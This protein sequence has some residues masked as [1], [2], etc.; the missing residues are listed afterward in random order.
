[1][2]SARKGTSSE[3]WHVERVALDVA[4]AHEAELTGE[5]AR[6]LLRVHDITRP[7]LVLGSTQR[8]TDVDDAAAVLA[9]VDVVRRRSGGGAVLLTPGDV[10]WIDVVVPAGDPLWRDDVGVAF[11]WLGEVWVHALNAVGVGGAAV[12]RGALVRTEWSD[13]VCFAGL[14]PGEVTLYGA[15]TI[16][17]SQRRTRYASRFQ[18]AA[19]LRWDVAALAPLLRLDAHAVIALERLATGIPVGGEHLVDAIVARMP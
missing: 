17:I 11:E 1:V 2:T 15:K 14:G 9:D 18:C 7:T 3:A 5:G 8:A 4:E 10:L 6:R 19:L 13:R 12:H 16:G